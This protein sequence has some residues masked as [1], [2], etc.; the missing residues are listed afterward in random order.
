[1]KYLSPAAI[2]VALVMTC[3]LLAQDA[4][5]DLEAMQGDWIV[6]RAED[7]GLELPRE[8]LAQIKISIKNDVMIFSVDGKSDTI[9]FKIVDATK[10]PRQIDLTPLSGP[11]KGQTYPGIYA[12]EGSRLRISGN[13]KSADRPTKFTTQSGSGCS[14]LVLEKAK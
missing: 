6:V 8:V 5:K 1:M 14:A 7:D 11:K 12:L 10:T 13:E 9:T 2:A 4:K 3:P